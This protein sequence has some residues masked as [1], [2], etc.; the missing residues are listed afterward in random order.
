MNRSPFRRAAEIAM[1]KAAPFKEERDPLQLSWFTSPSLDESVSGGGAG[2]T[3]VTSGGGGEAGN[4]SG[5]G[6]SVAG[7]GKDEEE[8]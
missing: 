3:S 5:A 2:N 8:G 4:I 7:D 1:G 6:S